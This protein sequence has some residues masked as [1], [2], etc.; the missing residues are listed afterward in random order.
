MKLLIAV[1]FG[2]YNMMTNMQWLLYIVNRLDGL[3]IQAKHML[4]R[5]WAGPLNQAVLLYR[6]SLYLSTERLGQRALIGKV[7][8][9]RE[10]PDYYVET[11]Q[12]S[13]EDTKK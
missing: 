5:L 1:T 3:L 11:T 12:E 2:N 6:Y 8:M 7:N 10:S 13:L 4:W 9:D